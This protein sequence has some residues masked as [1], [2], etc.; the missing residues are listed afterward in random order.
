MCFTI[1]AAVFMGTMLALENRQRDREAA[2]SSS[3]PTS[4]PELGKTGE[5]LQAVN[6]KI[7]GEGHE[8][9]SSVEGLLH[10]DRDLTDWEDRSF[11]Y[12]L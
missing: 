8:R 5:P 1:V 4:A 11:R 10:V 6:E 12:T 3:T 9:E 7:M 2:V